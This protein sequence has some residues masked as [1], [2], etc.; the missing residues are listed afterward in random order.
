MKYFFYTIAG[1]TLLLMIII[2]LALVVGSM[3]VWII[4]VTVYLIVEKN[5]EFKQNRLGI[6]Q[7]KESFGIINMISDAV[8]E[9]KKTG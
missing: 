6:K 7:K 3:P 8:K 4:P 5:I 9:S 1:I 2:L